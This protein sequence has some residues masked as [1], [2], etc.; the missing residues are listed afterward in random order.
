[1]KTI[2]SVNNIEIQKENDIV[3]IVT[4]SENHFHVLYRGAS[5][6]VEVVN[7]DYAN[8]TF[9]LIINKKLIT[10]QVKDKFDQMIAAL[11]MN[12]KSHNKASNIKAPMPGMILRVLVNTGERIKKG[13]VV[14]ILEAM[15]MENSIKAP[16]DGIIKEIKIQKGQIVEKNQELIALEYFI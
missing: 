4:I 6:A 16:H 2:Y 10:V 11:G 12:V 13:D 7:T 14:L 3:D 8:K 1:M 15:K 5:L 9:T